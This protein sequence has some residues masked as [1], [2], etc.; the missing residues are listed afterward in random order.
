MIIQIV[1]FDQHL[2]SLLGKLGDNK[3]KK[4]DKN[5]EN[6]G[7]CLLMKHFLLKGTVP[8]FSLFS[9]FG[10]GKTSKM[11]WIAVSGRADNY[12]YTYSV[13]S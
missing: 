12:S 4:I 6:A 10:A 8:E 5:H 13:C 1:E 11:L 2:I 7:F 9:N 3:R